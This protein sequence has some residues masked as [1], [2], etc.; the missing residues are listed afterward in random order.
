MPKFVTE[1]LGRHLLTF[2]DFSAVDHHILLVRAAVDS[3][4]TEGKIVEMHTRLLV[5]LY[6]G[7]PLR[8]DSRKG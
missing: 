4:G 5:L 6:S 7:A 2:A 8:R 3:E 1:F